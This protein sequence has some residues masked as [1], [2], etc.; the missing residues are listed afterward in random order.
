MLGTKCRVSWQC[1]WTT[2]C[3]CQMGGRGV[4]GPQ[5]GRVGRN[6]ARYF[7]LTIACVDHKKYHGRGVAHKEWCPLGGQS[8]VHCTHTFINVLS[9]VI[10]MD[11]CGSLPGVVDSVSD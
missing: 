1:G 7:Y 4:G 9:S 10:C 5:S 6:S 8:N 11:E 2:I 3:K